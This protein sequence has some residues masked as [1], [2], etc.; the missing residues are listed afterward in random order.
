MLSG[1][2]LGHAPGQHKCLLGGADG[3]RCSLG[4]AGRAGRMVPGSPE[5][6]D[7]GARRRFVASRQEPHYTV[8]EYLEMEAVAQAKHE[9]LDGRTHA[10]TGGTMNRA[11]IIATST[12]RSAAAPPSAPT[13]P[14]RATRRRTSRA[15]RRWRVTQ[16]TMHATTVAPARLTSVAANTIHTGAGRP[17]TPRHGWRDGVGAVGGAAGAARC[18]TTQKVGGFSSAR[19]AGSRRSPCSRTSRRPRRSRRGTSRCAAGSF[20]SRRP[21]ACRCSS[22]RRTRRGTRSR[23]RRR[24]RG[25]P[26][27]TPPGSTA[28]TRTGRAGRRPR[29]RRWR[30]RR[31][32]SPA[33]RTGGLYARRRVG[34]SAVPHIG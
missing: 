18:R 13:P 29:W 4:A 27:C 21:T 14:R 2:S 1:T 7:A 28:R 11:H 12:R 33:R 31:A 25:P 16:G 6:A 26:A 20:R 34:S 10:R 8:E 5:R 30:R 23:A 9:Y 22:R 3:V 24:P 17:L 19:G 32:R 15:E